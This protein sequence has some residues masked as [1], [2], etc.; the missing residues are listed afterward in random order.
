MAGV[1]GEESGVCVIALHLPILNCSGD[2]LCANLS[3]TEWGWYYPGNPPDKGG[4]GAAVQDAGP[5]KS[6]LCCACR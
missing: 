6:F 2:L 3:S 1:Q 5:L 4:I